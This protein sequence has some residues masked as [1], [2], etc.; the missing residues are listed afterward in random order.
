MTDAQIRHRLR[1]DGYEIGCKRVKHMM[2]EMKLIPYSQ[3]L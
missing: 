3:K 2:K 1:R